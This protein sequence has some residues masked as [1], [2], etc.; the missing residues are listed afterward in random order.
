MASALSNKRRFKAC[1]D[2]FAHPDAHTMENAIKSLFAE[3]A[4]IN[5]CHPFNELVGCKNYWDIFFKPLLTSFEGFHR[6]D[7]ILM[8][9]RFEEGDWIS[10][11]GYYTGHFIKPW[12]RIKPSGGMSYLRFGEFH[13][14]EGGTI[15]ESYIFLDLPELMIAGGQ[16]PIKS[17]PGHDRGYTGYLP[18]PASMDGLLLHETDPARSQSSADMVTEM[19]RKLATKDE[20]WRPYWHDNM[21]WYGPA[22]FGSFLGIENFAGFQVPFEQTLDGWAGGAVVGGK[23]RHFTR[24]GDDNY[25]CSGGWPSLHGV[26]VKPFLDQAATNKRLFMRVCDWWRREGDL[27]VENWVFVDIPHVLLQ[28]DFDL[29]A[30]IGEGA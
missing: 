10:C 22:A 23:T 1:M 17:S 18:G 24:F 28:M 26:Q 30:E 3:D 6:R 11:T 19:L 14:F 29:F 15:A 27:L 12:L 4:S 7:Y 13:R 25:V 2:A 20:A 9:N 16:W 21:A 8:G 5:I